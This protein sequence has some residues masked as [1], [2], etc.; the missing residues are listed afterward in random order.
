LDVVAAIPGVCYE[1]TYE[2]ESVMTLEPL[3]SRYEDAL[4]F[5]LRIEG[6]TLDT[7]HLLL[8]VSEKRSRISEAD[9]ALAAHRYLAEGLATLTIEEA[10][11]K[12]VKNIGFSSRVVSTRP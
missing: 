6:N 5:E 3:A 10:Y 8:G 7:T 2:E 1:Q 11:E 9:L 4:E 12:G